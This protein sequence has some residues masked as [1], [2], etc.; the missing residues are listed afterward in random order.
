MPAK[1]ISIRHTCPDCGSKRN[2]SKVA[3]C[4]RNGTRCR[5][6]GANMQPSEEGWRKLA[7]ANSA[8]MERMTR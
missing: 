6:C 3:A 1:G 5:N 8:R 2:I 7:E 4:R